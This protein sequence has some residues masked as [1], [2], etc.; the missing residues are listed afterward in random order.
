MVAR[1]GTV[2][3]NHLI[4]CTVVD[5]KI[6]DLRVAKSKKLNTFATQILKKV[7]LSK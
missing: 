2:L 3:S 4:Y 7:L 5:L 1:S 6:F